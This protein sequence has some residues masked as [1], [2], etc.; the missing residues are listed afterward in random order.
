MQRIEANVD[1]P[2]RNVDRSKANVDKSGDDVDGAGRVVNA[3]GDNVCRLEGY[4]GGFEDNV[5][6]L[7]CIV[8]ASTGIVDGHRSDVS[9]VRFNVELLRDIVCGSNLSPLRH[10]SARLFPDADG[11]EEW[12]GVALDLCIADAGEV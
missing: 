7:G 6:T 8:N 3:H 1:R 12:R 5:S 10:L 9:M 11:F 2:G 4:L